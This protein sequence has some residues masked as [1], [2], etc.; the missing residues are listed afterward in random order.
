MVFEN[1]YLQY[2]NMYISVFI[3]ERLELMDQQEAPIIERHLR[4]VMRA[5]IR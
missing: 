2:S 5:K 4:E 1:E 3:P